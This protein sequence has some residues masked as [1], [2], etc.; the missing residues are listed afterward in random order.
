MTPAFL[1]RRKLKHLRTAREAAEA[2]YKATCARGDTRAMH[3][4]LQALREATH[5]LMRLGG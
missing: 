5:K 4:A 1:R 3:E 2:R